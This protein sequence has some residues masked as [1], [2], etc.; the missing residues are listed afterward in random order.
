MRVVKGAIKLKDFGL[1]STNLT[2][3]NFNFTYHSY[4]YNKKY[5]TFW[6]GLSLQLIPC[7]ENKEQGNKELKGGYKNKII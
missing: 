5:N 4:T 6:Q 3:N 7:L 2:Y 1:I